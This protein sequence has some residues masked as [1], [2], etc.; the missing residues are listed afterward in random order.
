MISSNEDHIQPLIQEQFD[1][2]AELCH[3]VRMWDLDFR[4]MARRLHRLSTA[5]LVQATAQG[6]HYGYCRLTATIDQRGAAPPGMVTFVVKDEGMGPLWWRNLDTAANQILVYKVGTEVRCV[7]N[8]LFS[9]HTIS[10]TWETLERLCQSMRLERLCE[11][12]MP[13]VFRLDAVELSEIRANL[14]MLRD[15]IGLCSAATLQNLLE[16]LLRSWLVEM[17]RPFRSRAPLRVRDRAVKRCLE[18]LD[19]TDLSSVSMDQ[20]RSISDASERTLEYA[21][22]ERFGMSPAKFVKAK[23]LIEAHRALSQDENAHRTIADIA[24]EHGF[25]HHGHFT[26]D[27]RRLFGEPPHRA[28]L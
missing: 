11:S 12:I 21:F 19:A 9:V 7:S 24:A 25:W 23:R 6:I 28:R 16:T 15:G 10:A 1:D 26:A 27:Y 20:L 4:P 2:L 5:H 18:F 22:R 13:E 3:Q 14:R 17:G 8:A